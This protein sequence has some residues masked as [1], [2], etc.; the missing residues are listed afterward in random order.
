M[1][2][3]SEVLGHRLELLGLVFALL[4]TIWQSSLG[5]WWD[6]Q[7]PEWQYWIQEEVNI[8]VLNSIGNLAMLSQMQDSQ[9]K[10]DFAITL[11]NETS[12]AVMQAISMRDERAKQQNGAAEV[13]SNIG[14]VMY[15]LS[16]LL[17]VFGKFIVYRSVKI[18]YESRRK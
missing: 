7:G 15:F 2:K 12:T 5:G 4:A 3:K 10:Q 11:R 6:K 17:F 18:E 13:L 16:G 8:A 9:E 14:V 1:S